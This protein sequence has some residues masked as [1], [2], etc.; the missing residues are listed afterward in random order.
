MPEAVIVRDAVTIDEDVHEIY[1]QLTEGKD[2]VNSPFSTMKD[3]FMWAACVGFKKGDKRPLKG[4][5]IKIF[6]WTQFSPQIDIP[7]LKAMA[8]T[9]TKDIH[10]LQKQD[11]ILSNAEEYANGGIHEL[12]SHLLEEHGQPLWNLVQILTDH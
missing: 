2:P 1:K 10:I 9:N 8:L 7:I 3:L 12:R 4:K 5:R 6:T 11:E